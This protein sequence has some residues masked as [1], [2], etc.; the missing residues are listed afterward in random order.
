M[1]CQEF[2][3]LINDYIDEEMTPKSKKEFEGH[4]EGCA[5]CRK[6][7]DYYTGVVEGLRSVPE[8]KC[9]DSVVE[10]IFESVPMEREK[11]GVIKELYRKVTTRYGWEMK[12]V[13][14]AAVIIISVLLFYPGEVS[15]EVAEEPYIAGKVE[16][17]E[18]DLN[19][20]LDYLVYCYVKT[21]ST[22]TKKVIPEYLIKPISSAMVSSFKETINGG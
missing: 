9:P 6:A 1:T 16:L 3:D 20:A 2:N 13:A 21:E 5:K 14:A 11:P 22:I 8:E 7:L 15:M 19:T 17:V 10:R 4:L 18:K 12:F